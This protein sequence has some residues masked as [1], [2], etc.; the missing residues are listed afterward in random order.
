LSAAAET[1]VRHHLEARVRL[2]ERELVEH[3]AADDAEL[4]D[5]VAD[6][7]GD[8]V[9]A[10]EHEIDREVLDPGREVIAAAGDAQPGIAEQAAAVV[11]EAAGLLDGDVQTA[12]VTHRLFLP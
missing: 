5:A 6:E 7:G 11:R 3:V 10:D 1:E 8:V 4:A 9:V 12:V 2:T